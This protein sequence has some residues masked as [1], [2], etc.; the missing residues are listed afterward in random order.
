MPKLRREP[1]PFRGVEFVRA[2]S[3]GIVVYREELG[4]ELRAGGV[5]CELVDPAAADPA[6]GRVAVRCSTDGVFFARRHTMFARPDDVLGKIAGA[7]ELA[8]PRQYENRAVRRSARQSASMPSWQQ[9]L[10]QPC[11]RAPVRGRAPYCV[12]MCASVTVILPFAVRVASRML[13]LSRADV[14]A[15]L[16]VASCMPAMA[17]ALMGLARG[18]WSQPARSQFRLDGGRVVLGLMPAFRDNGARLLAL[19]DVARDPESGA[20]A[21]HASGCHTAS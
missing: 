21:G 18:G 3:A 13:I 19:K 2:P 7:A 20:R 5:V 4:A 11:R 10:Q 14:E 8:D 9:Q 17:A 12:I 6:K 16:D 1:V 15:V